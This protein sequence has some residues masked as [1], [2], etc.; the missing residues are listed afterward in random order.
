MRRAEGDDHRDLGD[1]H[2]IGC[3]EVSSACR[4]A[5]STLPGLL[6]EDVHNLALGFAILAC[7]A[8]VGRLCYWRLWERGQPL[9]SGLDTDGG[10]NQQ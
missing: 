1:N 9:T 6:Q 8:G 2:I 3:R 10:S 4:G 7:G 5:K